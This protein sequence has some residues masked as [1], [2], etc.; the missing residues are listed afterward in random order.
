[1]SASRLF[2][3]ITR[4]PRLVLAVALLLAALS[5]VYTSLKLEFLTGRDD[6]MPRHAAFQKDYQAYRAAFGDQ[7]EIAVVIEGTDPALVSRFS[8]ALYARLS[9]E[10]RL[11]LEVLYPGGMPYFRQNGLL[12][13]SLDE[14]KA[15]AGT[16][17]M[18]GPVLKDLAA[19]PSIQ[20]LFSSLTSQIDDYLKAPSPDKL[21]RLTFMLGTLDKGFAGF[22]GKKS[23]LSMDSF[24]SGGADGKPS[25]LENA[26]R[27]QVLAIRPLKETDSFVPA[28]KAIKKVREELNILRQKPEFKGITAG[29]TGV[30]VL[31]YEEMATSMDDMTIASVLSLLL[32]VILLLFAFRGV[33]NTV[34]AMVAL[35][36]AISI[37][38]GLATLFVGHLNIL[39]MAFAVMLL[40]LGVEYSIQVV[41]RHQEL[42]LHDSFETALQESLSSNLRPV[43]LAF[44]TTALAFLTFLLTD[45]RGIAELGLI[46]AMGVFVCFAATFTV[47]PA[48]LVLLHKKSATERPKPI[49]HNTTPP[50]QRL[51]A[52]PGLIVAAT[53]LLALTGTAALTRV[54]FDFNMLNLQAKG[55]ES[56]TYAYKLMKSKENSGYFGVSMAKDR[57]EAIRLTK[58]FEALPSVDHVVSLPAL[59]P[60]QQPEKLAELERIKQIM[61]KV[62]PVAYEENLRVMELPAIFEGFRERVEKLKNSLE[63]QKLPEAQP[64][65]AF[66]KTLDKFF[67][68]LEKEKDGN[69][70]TMLREMQ[71]AMFAPLPE[72]LKLLKESL[73]ARAV[74]EADVPQALKQRFVGKDGRLLLQIA[75][76]KEI[77]N[78]QP[79]AEFVTQIKTVDPHATGEPVSVYESFKILKLS[80]LEAFLYALGGVVLILLIAFRSLRSTL[81]GVTPLAAGLLLMVGGMWLFGLKFNVA[82]I[83]VMPLLLGVGIDSAIYIISRHLKGEESPVEVATSSAGKGVFL[84]ALTILFSFG[85]LMVARHQGVFSIGA[86]MSLGMTAIVLAFLVFLPALLLLLDRHGKPDAG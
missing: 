51:F 37:A 8:D 27:Q 77:F 55:L 24:L 47:L 2:G 11:F 18:A 5:I 35:L 29:I 30:P 81:L 26:G 46:A 17:E 54:P 9:Q 7:E 84:N 31:E 19:A 82:N 52:R 79:L 61:A 73:Q 59:V 1:M 22:D 6:L 50:L 86:V 23:A 64:I 58:R 3:A 63:A 43:L 28:E 34:A 68:G 39:S 85:A 42:L 83:I 13:M 25:A 80:Y 76:K 20:T 65:A 72:K 74:T 78:E 62:Q 40:G 36:I 53:A 38:F 21:Q 48:V 14:L 57:D 15:M 12:F 41:L 44:A 4:H 49:P 32:T 67:A 10:K 71:E 70:L 45:F 60:D 56:V 33:K 75:P 69:A 66:L 16:L